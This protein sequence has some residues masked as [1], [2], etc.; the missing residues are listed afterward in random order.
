MATSPSFRLTGAMLESE[1][2]LEVEMDWRCLRSTKTGTLRSENVSHSLGTR[3]GQ[4]VDDDDDC[5]ADDGCFLTSGCSCNDD[6]TLAMGVDSN[7]K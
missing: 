4:L 2:L 5:V 1:S 3:S 6:G 7:A